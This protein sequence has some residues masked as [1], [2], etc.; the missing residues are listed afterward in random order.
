M[1]IAALNATRGNNAEAGAAK[2]RP[3]GNNQIALVY[4]TNNLFA[5]VVRGTVRER[6]GGCGG[7]NGRCD[8]DGAVH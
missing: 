7:R 6:G 4:K 8:G 2:R 5:A 1:R 3:V